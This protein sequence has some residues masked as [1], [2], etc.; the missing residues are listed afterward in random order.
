MLMGI[1]SWTAALWIGLIA[2]AAIGGLVNGV[3]VNI[4]KHRAGKV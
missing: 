2:V 3:I 1:M 4:R